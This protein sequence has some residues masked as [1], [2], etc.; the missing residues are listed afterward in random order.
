MA[1]GQPLTRQRRASP[2]NQ[3]SIPHPFAKPRQPGA[4]PPSSFSKPRQPGLS[5]TALKYKRS[6]RHTTPTPA[7][8]PL[9]SPL[10]AGLSQIQSELGSLKSSHPNIG[11]P[12]AFDLP[13]LSDPSAHYLSRKPGGGM[14]R[15]QRFQ[16]NPQS[17]YMLGATDSGQV[18][19]P[20]EVSLYGNKGQSEADVWYDQWFAKGFCKSNPSQCESLK[21]LKRLYNKPYQKLL[22]GIPLPRLPE[23]HDERYVSSDE[24]YDRFMKYQAGRYDIDEPS[25]S[26]EAY[27]NDVKARLKDPRN[28]GVK[29]PSLDELKRMEYNL[30]MTQRGKKEGW[31]TGKMPID[32]SLYA[33]T[34]TN[35]A[36][37]YDHPEKFKSKGEFWDEQHQN[38]HWWDYLSYANPLAQLHKAIKAEDNYDDQWTNPAHDFQEKRKYLYEHPDYLKQHPEDKEKWMVG[39]LGNRMPKSWLGNIGS[40]LENFAVGALGAA[41]NP[42]G[43]GDAIIHSFKDEP[44]EAIK[45]ECSQP[46]NNSQQCV[47]WR[48]LLS[49]YGL[50]SIGDVGWQSGAALDAPIRSEPTINK[51]LDIG[52]HSALALAAAAGIAEEGLGRAAAAAE[53]GLESSAGRAASTLGEE[54]LPKTTLS[55]EEMADA[56]RAKDSEIFDRIKP[57]GSVDHAERLMNDLD[58]RIN[59]PDTAYTDAKSTIDRANT[60]VQKT[61]DSTLGEETLPKT[62]LPGGE[63]ADALALPPSNSDVFKTFDPVKAEIGK[64]PGMGTAPTSEQLASNE[65]RMRSMRTWQDSLSPEENYANQQDLDQFIVDNDQ[66]RKWYENPKYTEEQPSYFTHPRYAGKDYFKTFDKDLMNKQADTILSD[67]P[68]G[69]RMRMNDRLSILQNARKSP[70][71]R[72]TLNQGEAGMGDKLDEVSLKAEMMEYGKRLQ[73]FRPGTKLPKPATYAKSA[74]MMDKARWRGKQ[75]LGK[76]KA[77]G[78]PGKN[79]LDDWLGLR[80]VANERNVNEWLSELDNA[81]FYNRFRARIGGEPQDLKW[82]K[83]AT[84]PTVGERP[85]MV[86]EAPSEAA[87]VPKTTLGQPTLP[88]AV[89]SE[90][91]PVPKTTLGQ[92]TLPPAVPSEAAPVPKTTLGQQTLPPAVPSEVAPV[93][94]T[95][96]GQQTLPPAVL[97]AAE[98]SLAD[99]KQSGQ[100]YKQAI[101]DITDYTNR[102]PQS[103]FLETPTK[104]TGTTIPDVT[105]TTT[106]SKMMSAPAQAVTPETKATSFMEDFSKDLKEEPS[107]LLYR[108]APEDSTLESLRKLNSDAQRKIDT[109]HII[110]EKSFSDAY[111]ANL[112]KRG[113]EIKDIKVAERQQIEDAVGEYERR[114]D[115]VAVLLKKA[116]KPGWRS[117]L[118][119]RPVHKIAAKDITS[120][121]LIGD[122]RKYQGTDPTS[123]FS[124]LE[125]LDTYMSQ[126]PPELERFSPARRPVMR[127]HPRS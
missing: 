109:T 58:K 1:F 100:V 37:I 12:T 73:R 29:I 16:L 14:T 121:K 111:K 118:K 32:P 41:T 97:E 45:K 60:D 93:P 49:V 64:E 57:K 78:L 2:V 83:G 22:A 48:K 10:R 30:K 3:F 90:A 20:H 87:P 36:A 56:W 108:D 76:G 25:M 5:P 103:R 21:N 26:K 61:F 119:R 117:Y 112:K 113:W 39:M 105:G 91:A 101:G 15:S 13:K 19:T 81:K 38:K 43:A 88:P 23:K 85:T 115:K 122:L 75:M 65:A 33:H 52:G 94:K 42:I 54:T 7:G 46:G 102:P 89:P 95:T 107:D 72:W 63:T 44:S 104:R 116:I 86:P 6:P 114:R 17:P 27:M 8:V 9:A 34:E 62:T 106:R 47:D 68:A 126:T 51:A 99:I 98:Q 40:G 110:N 70:I 4:S 53:G 24:R 18:K 55:G 67:T 71:D 69:R 59:Q 96:L 84:Y 11:V 123:R 125:K 77:E 127:K 50:S 35:R 80:F 79:A 92:P 120:D 124:N 82:A 66:L 74:R 31:P 28:P